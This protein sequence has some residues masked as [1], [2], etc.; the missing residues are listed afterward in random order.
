MNLANRYLIIVSGPIGGR[1]EDIVGL[2]AG[3]AAYL[4]TRTSERK[5]LPTD[6]DSTYASVVG[7]VATEHTPVVV[8]SP[9]DELKDSMG[10][11]TLPA[12]EQ[13]ANDRSRLE[14]S[15][16][17]VRAALHKGY[18]IVIVHG[19]F[20]HDDV[21]AIT[22]TA[23]TQPNL[24]YEVIVLFD[25]EYRGV[26]LFDIRKSK[27]HQIPNT[28]STPYTTI[29]HLSHTFVHKKNDVPTIPVGTRDDIPSTPV[30]TE[31]PPVSDS[32]ISFRIQSTEAPVPDGRLPKIQ[33][34][35]ASLL[36]ITMS[37][38]ELRRIIDNLPY[39]GNLSH[40]QRISMRDHRIRN[41]TLRRFQ[42]IGIS[43]E[44]DIR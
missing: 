31:G 3:G 15:L 23:K 10:R 6:L 13:L 12:D 7:A 25:G 24:P 17:K 22:E 39:T 30:P 18:S 35:L 20:T 19:A 8:I 2:L 26:V 14:R 34:M 9:E 1:R 28:M 37:R 44:I 32:H 29:T 36:G 16:T 27:G 41:A 43:V 21:F 42:E 4:S 38:S 11:I 40:R 33:E 5:D